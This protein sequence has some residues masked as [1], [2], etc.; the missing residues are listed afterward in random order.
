MLGS[1]FGTKRAAW[2][3]FAPTLARL[4]LVSSTL[5]HDG[6]EENGMTW[7]SPEHDID[8]HMGLK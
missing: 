2:T 7:G 1:T 4:I 3:W 5:K 8:M 6:S